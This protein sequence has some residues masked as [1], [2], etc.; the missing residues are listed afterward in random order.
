MEDD[1]RN[2]EESGRER[3]WSEIKEKGNEMESN[4]NSMVSGFCLTATREDGGFYEKYLNQ[5]FI[6]RTSQLTYWTDLRMCV[7]INKYIF[8]SEKISL[9]L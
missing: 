1:R 6:L 3:E 2:S 5:G 4:Q 8:L 7:Y 9:F